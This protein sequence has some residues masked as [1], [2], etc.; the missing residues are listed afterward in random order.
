[1]N[2]TICE[3][4]QQ[5]MEYCQWVKGTTKQTLI[6]YRTAWRTW[7]HMLE[8]P[9]TP[10]QINNIIIAM[11]KSGRLSDVTINTYLQILKLRPGEY[12]RDSVTSG[13]T[14]YINVDCI[15]RVTPGTWDQWW[16]DCARRWKRLYATQGR[17]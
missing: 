4:W 6:Y 5:Y 9:I 7:G 2:Q 16:S 3:W 1:M 12:Q 13:D 17:F 11:R 14:V 15:V 10:Q 8:A